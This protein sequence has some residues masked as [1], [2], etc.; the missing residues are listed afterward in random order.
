MNETKNTEDIS[1]LLFA[2][3][4]IG[5]FAVGAALTALLWHLV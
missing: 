2:R 4:L 3:Q 1:P 5:G